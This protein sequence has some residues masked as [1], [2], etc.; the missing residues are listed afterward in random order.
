MSNSSTLRRDIGD[1]CDARHAEVGRLGPPQCYDLAVRDRVARTHQPSRNR[2][3]VLELRGGAGM[4]EAPWPRRRPAACPPGR[5]GE[6][7][8]GKAPGPAVRGRWS[9]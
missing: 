9:M 8:T 1:A 2:T 4:G 5:D 7:R 6:P 3:Y